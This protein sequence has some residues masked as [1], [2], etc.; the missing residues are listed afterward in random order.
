MKKIFISFITLTLAIVLSIGNT[1]NAQDSD[2]SEHEFEVASDDIYQTYIEGTGFKID[3]SID[4]ASDENVNVIVEFNALAPVMSNKYKTKGADVKTSSEIAAM[5]NDFSAFVAANNTQVNSSNG[6]SSGSFW[7]I[8]QTYSTTYVGV[9]MTLPAS[10]LEELATASQVLRIWPDE[11]V[12][13]D[14]VVSE[15]LRANAST[16]MNVTVPALGIDSLHAEGINGEGIKVGILDTGIDYNH[17]D[18][19]Q[20]YKGYVYTTD[21]DLANQTMNSVKGWDFVD[22]D[23]DPMETTYADWKAVE[24][25]YYQ[26]VSGR[27]YWTSHGTHVSGTVAGT[28]G[29][30]ESEFATLGVAP[31]SSLYGYRVLGPY[32]SGSVGSILGGI[33]KSV[34]D[35]M[36]IINLSLGNS[37]SHDLY[38]TSIA[39][40]NAALSGVVPVVAAGNDGPNFETIGSP[41][42]SALAITVGASNLDRKY[43][44]STVTSSGSEYRVEQMANNFENGL[45]A[46]EGQT[47]S[48][49]YVGLGEALD[50]IR[51]GGSTSGNSTFTDKLVL[52]QR[53]NISFD[54]K[55]RRA[56][57]FGAKGAIIYNNIDGDIPYYLPLNT[58]YV[59]TFKLSK[60]DGE[61]LLASLTKTTNPANGVVKSEGEVTF[62][63]YVEQVEKRNDLAALSSVGP[64]LSNAAIKPDVVAPGVDILSAYPADAIAGTT[65][66]DYSNAYSQIQGTSMATPHVSGLVALMLQK[67]PN[68]TVEQVKAIIT[69]TADELNSD[70]SVYQTGGGRISPRDAV[71]STYNIYVNGTYRSY[72]SNFNIVDLNH[73]AN[74]IEYG[75]IFDNEQDYSL[76]K[77]I[78]LEQF[79]SDSLDLSLSVEYTPASVDDLV[80]DSAANNVQLSLSSTKLTSTV[81][82]TLNVPKSAPNGLYEG[83]IV[84]TNNNNAKDVRYIP[85]GVYKKTSGLSDLDIYPAVIS[86]NCASLPRGA[87]LALDFS[88]PVVG[89]NIFYVNNGKRVGIVRQLDFSDYPILPSGPIQIFDGVSSQLQSYYTPFDNSADGLADYME[90]IDPGVADLEF[91]VTFE[92]GSTDT[93][94]EE[95]LVS[96]EQP[97]YENISGINGLYEY[98]NSE[99]GSFFNPKTVDVQV[100]VIDPNIEWLQENAEHTIYANEAP[101]S[102]SRNFVELFILDNGVIVP[103]GANVYVGDENGVIDLGF[104][105]KDAVTKASYLFNAY[106]RYTPCNTK[107]YEDVIAFTSKNTP[108][109]YGRFILDKEVYEPEEN[110]VGTYNV[111][112]AVG[113]KDFHISRLTLNRTISGTTEILS[114]GFTDEFLAYQEEQGVV[115]EIVRDENPYDE[116][117]LGITVKLISAPDGYEGVTGSFPLFNIEYSGKNGATTTANDTVGVLSI[118]FSG[119]L[120]NDTKVAFI[121][122]GV[123]ISEYENNNAYAQII[124]TPEAFTTFRE[125]GEIN[126]SYPQVENFEDLGL[127]VNYQSVY[128]DKTESFHGARHRVYDVAVTDKVNQFE[129]SVPGHLTEVIRYRS[130]VTE[131]GVLIG[132]VSGVQGVRLITPQ[133]SI[134]AYAGDVNGDEVID[135][136]DM[137][138]A[139]EQLK[140]PSARSAANPID[141][142]QDG[143]VDMTDINYIVNNQGK[144]G[145]LATSDPILAVDKY[146]DVHYYLNM[147]EKEYSNFT[148]RTYAGLFADD[149][150]TAG[151]VAQLAEDANN[152]VDYD[153]LDTITEINSNVNSEYSNVSVFGGINMLRGLET[154]IINNANVT[155]V[156]VTEE[157]MN[158]PLSTINLDNNNITSF[159]GLKLENL[160][161][162]SLKSNGLVAFNDYFA[163]YEQLDL[164]IDDNNIIDFSEFSQLSYKVNVGTQHTS[165][166]VVTKYDIDNTKDQYMTF[167]LPV[168]VGSDG[169]EINYAEALTTSGCSV[170]GN[171][172]KCL[173]DKNVTNYKLSFTF[174]DDIDTNGEITVDVNV[175]ATVNEYSSELAKTGNFNASIVIALSV[176]AMLALR[177]KMNKHL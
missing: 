159:E 64:V 23:A 18:L 121:Y 104:E 167:E 142:N 122:Y 105:K 71:E 133:E 6:T 79:N 55:I 9:A 103:T 139:Y 24:G 59:P 89:M 13:I 130:G 141:I 162:L 108:E 112:N 81:E 74:S 26:T 29:N 99:F 91:E 164:N 135:V 176:I 137:K 96:Y 155:S 170:D 143:V 160:T 128:G 11:E 124:A 90:V 132:F 41:G 20:S 94:F 47:D 2:N 114:Y 109:T 65:S 153:K 25:L 40:N 131:N 48:I 73:R 44:E 38:P 3:P 80:Q 31:N 66:S 14:P 123:D 106:G 68:L 5:H 32:G 45:A 115:Y 37:Y 165:L 129:I 8:T 36:D 56:K 117:D 169:N 161:S 30:T 57:S 116:V 151:V 83:R 87:R 172:A 19:S 21:A 1:I 46:L 157:Y 120:M 10:D 102:N 67:N 54:E 35:G 147:L 174:Q 27:T 69:N 110:I 97:S 92:D 101:Y 58:D 111:Y 146:K 113:V 50:Y 39:L 12:Q 61:A 148:D 126:V 166:D 72:D 156:E 107:E 52:I 154:L 15:K 144:V 85:F 138:M 98:D 136:L 63:T 82:A 100:Q 145:F 127:T 150:M 77:T 86:A 78:V 34:L 152:V 42:T 118:K 49:I 140:Q 158:L 16:R 168:I 43:V 125:N 7:D 134:T 84:V 4:L 76:T 95:V 60:A 75:D 163:H 28:A 119:T 177:K 53:G 51:L 33:E 175:N 171:V 149:H 173:I 17:P 88:Q 93:R 70:Y 22:N 62:G